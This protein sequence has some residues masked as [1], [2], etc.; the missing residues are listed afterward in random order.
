MQIH[1][2]IHDDNK[3]SLWEFHYLTGIGGKFC[4]KNCALANS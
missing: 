1:P 2:I 3:H 4:G